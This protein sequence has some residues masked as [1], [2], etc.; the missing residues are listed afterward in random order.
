MK[1]VL[2]AL[3]IVCLAAAG[4]SAP[5]GCIKG[6][7]FNGTG[8]YAFPSG[9]KYSGEFE[10]GMYNGTGKYYF[11]DGRRYEGQFRNNKFSGEGVYYFTNGVKYKGEFKY[12]KMSGRGTM[13]FPSGKKYVGQFENN[14]FHGWGVYAFPSGKKIEGRWAK[15]KLLEDGESAPAPESVGEVQDLG[16]EE[17]EVEVLSVD[18]A[19]PAGKGLDE[20][21]VEDQYQTREDREKEEL[22]AI[23]AYEE[24]LSTEDLLHQIK[25]IPAKRVADNLRIYSELLR[26][27]PENKTYQKKVKYY[28]ALVEKQK[29]KKK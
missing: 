8:T 22:E 14:M 6:N 23:K 28:K 10:E 9:E 24:T 13:T 16:P 11:P 1:V 15:N 25:Y 3:V 29:G 19:F 20:A 26:R 27:Y 17:E 4:C 2:S 12:G 21:T 7:C 5:Q 18:D